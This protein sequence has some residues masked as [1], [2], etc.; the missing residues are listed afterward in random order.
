LTQRIK[1][2]VEN[3]FFIEKIKK[4]ENLNKKVVDKLK[5]II[6]PNLKFPSNITVL[7]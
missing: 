3:A 5:K 2:N 6:K 1:R 4:L 7:I